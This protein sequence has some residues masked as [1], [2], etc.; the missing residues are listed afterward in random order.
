M[1][2]SK[3]VFWILV[4]LWFAGGTWWYSSCSKCTSCSTAVSPVAEPRNLPGFIVSDSNWNL[5]SA[6][7]LKFGKSAADPVI[8]AD[9][10][11]L[12]DSLVVYAKN[13]PGKLLRVTGYFQSDETYTGSFENLGWARADG[14]K[15]WLESHGVP[16]KNI[17]TQSELSQGLV[18][19]PAD[20]L[21]GGIAIRFISVIET[22]VKED[23]FQPRTVYFNTGKN[24]L[25]VD[26]AFT[27]YIGK[28]ENY[29]QNHS[30]KKLMITGY[31]DNAGDAAKNMSLSVS[32]ASF[33][34]AELAKKGI[35]EN[36]MES[37]GKGMNEPVADNSTD[38]GRSKNRRATIQLQ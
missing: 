22:T 38:D 6:A 8:G 27:S 9:I 2:L 24:S 20:T 13:T 21:V 34:K 25:P 12:L 29:L 19:S 23:L 16:E 36:R 7:N 10:M 18:F 3:P 33:I 1:S 5:S 32:R 4:F 37:T 15:K 26:T 17:I 31:T 35:P 30:D 14:M 11:P 28:V